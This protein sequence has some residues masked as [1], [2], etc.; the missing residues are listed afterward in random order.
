MNFY[1]LTFKKKTLLS[2]ALVFISILLLNVTLGIIVNHKTTEKTFLAKRD[3]RIKH[4]SLNDNYNNDILFIGTSRTMYHISTSIFEKSGLNIANLGI[5]GG[6]YEDYPTVIEK[7]LYSKPRKIVI[8]LQIERFYS[9]LSVAE[10]PGI[11]EM[12]FYFDI[13]KMKFLYSLFAN[14]RSYHTFLIYSESIYSN[15]KSIYSL[16]DN[17][18]QILIDDKFTDISYSKM[19]DCIVFEKKGNKEVR[20]ENG[21]G[22]LFGNNIDLTPKKNIFIINY[23]T[24]SI[25]YFNKIIKK[26]KNK[27]IEVIVVLEPKFHNEYIYNL[28]SLKDRLNNTQIIDLTN[29]QISDS[30]WS[31]NRHLNIMGRKFY[32]EHLIQVLNKQNQ[33]VKL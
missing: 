13:D 5:P 33:K 26:I 27:N 3:S 24:D 19:I 12:M 18:K 10:N 4:F 15:I 32:T 7:V 31:E 22:I 21:D 9:D 28:N 30:S 25:R 17:S 2:I 23:D 16:F 1:T 14:L 20:C 8:S 6:T 29:L 11:D